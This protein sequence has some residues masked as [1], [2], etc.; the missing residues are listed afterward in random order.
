MAVTEDAVTAPAIDVDA[1]RAQASRAGRLLAAMR[2][3]KRLL[4]LCQLVGGELAVNDLAARLDT[5][6]STISQHLALLRRDGLVV[7]RGEGPTR[8]Y[9]LAG[10]EARAIL[11]TLQMLYCETSPRDN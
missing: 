6:Q 9:S 11:E 10:H 4:I 7:S 8:F 1:M 5:R 2:N 3:E